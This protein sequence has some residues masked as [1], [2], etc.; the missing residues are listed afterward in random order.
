M[1]YLSNPPEVNSTL[2]YTGPGPSSFLAAATSWDAVSAELSSAAQNYESVLSALT[3]LDWKGPAAAAMNAVAQQYQ[4][5]LQTTAEET[6]QVAVQARAAAAAFEQALRATVPPPAVAANRVQQAALVA[7]NYLGQN[8]AAIAALDAQYADYWAQDVAAMAGY[9]ASAAAARQLPTFTSPNQA[10]NASGLAAQH[11]AVAA[12]GTSAAGSA[13][14]SSVLS[15]VSGSAAAVPAQIIPPIVPDD[16]TI[17]DEVVFLFTATNSTNSLTQV[18]TNTIGA[19]N[20]LGILPNLGAEAVAEEV[21]AALAPA[22]AEAPLGGAAASLGGAGLGAGLGEVSATLAHAG[23][24]GP[25]SVPAS[26]SAPS[27]STVTALEPAGMTILPGTE[28][29]AASGYPGYPGMPGAISR[30]SGVGAPPRYGVR[31]TVMPRPPAA[32]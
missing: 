8:T 28:E 6:R 27:T 2:I 7:T 22:I 4:V 11:S 29:V 25:M 3:S 9:D 21:P 32:G 13:S 16:F 15:G 12:A 26:W 20:N 24:I 30:G 14:A 18:V 19:M 31:L 1:N 5:W 23:T 10:T 17:L